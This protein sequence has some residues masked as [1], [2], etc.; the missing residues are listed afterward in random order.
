MKKGRIDDSYLER[1][2]INVRDLMF[3]ITTDCNLRCKHCYV[4]ESKEEKAEF[5]RKEAIDILEHFGEKG[6][7][8]LTFLGGEPTIHPN[9]SELIK[10]ASNFDIREKRM[11]TNGIDSSFLESIDHID[12][13]HISFSLDGHRPELHEYIRGA[14]TFKKTINSIK[15]AQGKGFDT[16][17]TY[18]VNGINLPFVEEGLSFFHELGVNTVNFHLTSMIGTAAENNQLYVSPSQWRSLRNRLLQPRKGLEGLSLR[19]PLMFLDKE[20]YENELQNGYS[21]LIDGSYHSEDGDRILLYPDGRVYTCC[22]LSSSKFNFAFYEN[23]KFFS[24]G[25]TNELSE[26]KKYPNHPCVATKLLNNDTEGFIPVCISYKKKI[27]FD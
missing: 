25:E 18:T 8:R 3:Y 26:F 22:K 19:V 9:I 13:D 23:K 6:L 12:L 21:C 17:V 15:E 20:E 10:I 14:G 27:T 16:R 11:T 1:E 5:S 2:G 24:N 7:E 4:G